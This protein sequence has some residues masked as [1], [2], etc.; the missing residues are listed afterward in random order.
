MQLIRKQILKSAVHQNDFELPKHIEI[1]QKK[2]KKKKTNKQE[3][4]SSYK[5]SIQQYLQPSL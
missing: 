1:K 4:A 2:K 3:R 5:S